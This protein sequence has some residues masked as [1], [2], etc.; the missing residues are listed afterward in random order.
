MTLM[1]SYKTLQENSSYTSAITRALLSRQTPFL[2]IPIWKWRD[3]F[4]KKNINKLH[5][6]VQQPSWRYCLRMFS[7]SI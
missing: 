5:G 2:Q 3:F 6:N 4:E 7:T 1:P